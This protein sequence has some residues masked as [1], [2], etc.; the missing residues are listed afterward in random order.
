MSNIKAR[1]YGASGVQERANLS[2]R[3]HGYSFGTN[4][5]RSKYFPERASDDHI[6][7]NRWSTITHTHPKDCFAAGTNAD[8]VDTT[9]TRHKVVFIIMLM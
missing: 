9:A 1:S 8:A 7:I 3:I 6:E 5:N 2:R 4:S